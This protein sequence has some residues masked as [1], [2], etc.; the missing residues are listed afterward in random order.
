MLIV[1][2]SHP[3]LT[4]DRP[5]ELVFA[6]ARTENAPVLFGQTNFFMQF[7]V[8]FDALAELFEVYPNT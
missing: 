8:C 6:W 7:R 2:G 5:V 4:P 1:E 3:Q